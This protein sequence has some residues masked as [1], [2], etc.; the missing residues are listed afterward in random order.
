MA[1]KV[2]RSLVA[3]ESASSAPSLSQQ[4]RQLIDLVCASQYE[5]GFYGGMDNPYSMSLSSGHGAH[6]NHAA[7]PPP[8]MHNSYHGA[9]NHVMSNNVMGAIPDVHK[10]DKDAIY[11]YDSHIHS[12]AE[13]LRRE[14]PCQYFCNVQ[15]KHRSFHRRRRRRRSVITLTLHCLLHCHHH[16]CDY[17]HHHLCLGDRRINVYSSPEQLSIERRPQT[18]CCFARRQCSLACVYVCVRA[19]SQLDLIAHHHYLLGT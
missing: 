15:Q 10:R 14:L 1:H 18:R 13:I 19:D 7:P 4:Q 6:L 2:S 3:E 11:R 16:H 9:N 12:T 8:P 17:C 5:D